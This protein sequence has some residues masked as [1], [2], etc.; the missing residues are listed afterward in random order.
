MIEGGD[1]VW[2]EGSG[3]I[4]GGSLELGYGGNESY[5][6]TEGQGWTELQ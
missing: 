2:L 5:F 6:G 4:T 3:R 1:G